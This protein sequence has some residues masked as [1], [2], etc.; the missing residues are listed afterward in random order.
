EAPFN[1][2]VG[3]NVEGL[4]GSMV[5]NGKTTDVV[6]VAHLLEDIIDVPDSG[7]RA[8]V[9]D[10]RRNILLVEDS[11]FFRNLTAPFLSAAG[12]EVIAVGSARE[13]LAILRADPSQTDIIVTD[14]EMP[15]MNGFAFAEECKRD[16]EL[17]QIPIFAFTSTV[18]Q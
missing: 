17:R 18:N 7:L 16:V 8:A 15:D 1:I 2:K 14:I 9:Q 4:L 6:D 13:A 11:P 5:I 12:F 10:R 3:S